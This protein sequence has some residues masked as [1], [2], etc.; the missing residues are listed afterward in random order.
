MTAPINVQSEWAPLRE[1]VYGAPDTFVLSV[2]HDDAQRL[3][4]TRPQRRTI[5]RLLLQEF[6]QMIETMP[7]GSRHSPATLWRVT[8]E[9]WLRRQSL[10]NV[11]RTQNRNVSTSLIQ[12]WSH[13]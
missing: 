13:N 5:F 12:N 4:W 8:V 6:G 7:E 11:R 10:I 3:R 9:N 2:F 1:C